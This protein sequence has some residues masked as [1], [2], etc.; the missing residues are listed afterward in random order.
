MWLINYLI[1]TGTF[2]LQLL[3]RNHS[4]VVKDKDKPRPLVDGG[5]GKENLYEGKEE[6]M[7]RQSRTASQK[8]K[9]RIQVRNSKLKI[10][11]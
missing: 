10:N 6:K 1:T 11:R 5:G 2:F 9:E 7:K 3:P 8:A 4:L